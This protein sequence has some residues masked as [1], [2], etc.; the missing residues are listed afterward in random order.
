MPDRQV[1]AG[2][3]ASLLPTEEG[4]SQAV[5]KAA[6]LMTS[7]GA[8]LVEAVRPAAGSQRQTP[9]LRGAGPPLHTVTIIHSLKRHITVCYFKS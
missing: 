9:A 1:Q 7:G 3:L 8:L 6:Q 4:M 2:T 5:H